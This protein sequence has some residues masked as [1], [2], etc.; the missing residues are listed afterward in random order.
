MNSQS[1]LM[2]TFS[3]LVNCASN[4][5]L[6]Y[7]KIHSSFSLHG[8]FYSFFSFPSVLWSLVSLLFCLLHLY[9]FL[10]N[11]TFSFVLFSSIHPIH[12]RP[13]T[14]L[15]PLFS[16]YIEHCSHSCFVFHIIRISI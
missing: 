13:D 16:N 6:Q 7:L 11:M 2:I 1:A 8:I 3:N 12:L 14:E 9:Y 10:S 5:S 4:T 15:F